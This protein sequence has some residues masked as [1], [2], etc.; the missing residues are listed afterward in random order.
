MGRA[1]T[2]R[3]ELQFDA[4]YCGAQWLYKNESHDCTKYA[5]TFEGWSTLYSIIHVNERGRLSDF[6][7]AVVG[8]HDLVE[9]V[10]KSET[11]LSEENATITTIQKM[12][13]GLNHVVTT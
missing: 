6:L 9:K 5:A 4:I 10:R 8:S 2:W 12:L 1:M 3:I 7:N 13:Q 11:N